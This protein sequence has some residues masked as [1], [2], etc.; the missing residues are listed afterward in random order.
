MTV[1]VASETTARFYLNE[2]QQLQTED[3]LLRAVQAKGLAEFQRLGFPDRHEEDWR[4]TPVTGFLKHSFHCPHPDA[5][6][7]AQVILNKQTDVP[8]GNKLVFVDGVLVGLDALRSELPPGVLVMPILDAMQT[9]PDK[10]TP[11]LNKV[12]DPQHGFHAQNTAML[13]L[14]LFIYVPAHIRINVP[15]LL[16]HWQ[17]RSDQALYFR[18]VVVLESGAALDLIEDYQG[19]AGANYFTNTVT[20]VVASSQAVLRHYKVQ[21]ESIAAW[22]VGHLAVKLATQSRVES[23]IISMGAVWSRFDACFALNEPQAECVLNGIYIPSGQQHMDHHTWVHHNAPNG[24]SQQ[25]YKGIVRDAA[26]AVFNGQV[27]VAKDAQKTIAQQKNKNLLLSKQAEVDTKPQL[28]I[29]ADDVQCTHGA[30]VG[31]LDIDALFYFATRGISVQDATQYL[32]QAF[33]ADNLR[34]IG[35]DDFAAWLQSRMVGAHDE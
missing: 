29:A 25:D 20:E 5:P 2:A 23:H 19:Q 22:H 8:W 18:H 13:Q 15:I 7:N 21:R 17:T 27:H 26:H 3:T 35:H 31:Q 12:L 16:V 10:I 30:T 14:G 4:Y 33:A 32:I 11:H 34:A 28:D 1:A 24:T 9:V 6:L